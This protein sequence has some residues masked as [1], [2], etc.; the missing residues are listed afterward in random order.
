MPEKFR[1]HFERKTLRQGYLLHLENRVVDVVFFRL[2]YRAEVMDGDRRYV[3]HYRHRGFSAPSLIGNS[4]CSCRNSAPTDFCAHQAALLF[5]VLSTPSGAPTTGGKTIGESYSASFWASLALGLC[6]SFGGLP[7]RFAPEP[8][9]VSLVTSENA[10]VLGFAIENDMD[11]LF[12]AFPEKWES[13]ASGHLFVAWAREEIQPQEMHELKML[14]HTPAKRAEFGAAGLACRV[15]FLLCLQPRGLLNWQEDRELFHIQ[16]VDLASDFQALACLGVEPAFSL[17][18]KFPQIEL[19]EGFG[20]EQEIWRKGLEIRVDQGGRLRIRPFATGLAVSNEEVTRMF[21]PATGEGLW[22]GDRNHLPGIG[23]RRLQP[24]SGALFQRYS[25]WK[26][27]WVEA[28]A[29]SG[30]L[31]KY[32]SELTSGPDYDL[33]P[34]LERSRP[35][36][37]SRMRVHRIGREENRFRVNLEYALG[38]TA[39]DLRALHSLLDS[40]QTC[41]ITAG[42]WVDLSAPEWSWLSRLKSGDWVREGEGMH[43]LLDRA[44]L[45]RICVMH[46]PVAIEVIS[47]GEDSLDFLT[48]L[49]Q[50]NSGGPAI[51]FGEAQLPTAGLRSYQADGLRWLAQLADLGL[52]GI[53][54]DDMGLGKTHQVMA[55]CAWLHERSQGREKF[56]IVCPTSVLYH[57]KEKFAKFHPGLE[58]GVYHGP[59]R[60]AA[61]L[62]LPLCITSYGIARNDMALFRQR[63]YALLVLDEI[64]YSKNRD[65]ETHKSLRD[66]PARSTIG[67]TG[68][69]LENSVWEVKNLFDLILPG[70]FPGEAQFR[71]EIAEPLEAI[72]ARSGGIGVPAALRAQADC[73]RE[74]FLRLTR[75][76]MLRRLKSQVLDDLPEKIEETYHCEMTADQADLYHATLKKRGGPLLSELLGARPASLMHVFQ[77]LN[78]LKQICNHPMTLSGADA[79]DREFGSGKWELF[80]FLLEKSLRSGHKVVVFSQYLNMLAWM[81]RH[82]E[83]SGIGYVTLTG[84]TTHRQTVLNRFATDPECRVFCCSLKAGGVG[85]DLTAAETVIHYDRWWNAARENQ[86][87]DRVHRIGQL[88]NVQVFK[89]VT[90]GTIEDR[91][92][93]IIQRKAD[94]MD[95]LIPDAEGG[96]QLFTREELVELLRA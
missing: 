41:L 6:R 40:G 5:R 54:A 16:V 68:T 58:T 31:A 32:S 3:C 13:S 93:A 55:L 76:F 17:H 90:R 69:P 74:R 86:A 72:P 27:Y 33:D 44:Q 14:G 75:P 43:A 39:L 28:H 92:D 65:S 47:T 84:A 8:G 94:F 77:L 23:F 82:L 20:N 21:P 1:K 2:V 53:L 62:D 88:K 46:A 60:D 79:P 15:A 78:H 38:D 95:S 91:I 85:I 19:G 61:L 34:I 42:G 9:R 48:S 50:G 57:W 12:N 49:P 96:L 26:T 52:S 18:K 22:F 63:R 35:A 7:L 10:P 37:I 89:L 87:T 59:Q 67:L 24:G 81:E 71:G 70:Y 11:N 64:H 83:K 29:V 30:F 51:A 4:E 66:F 36:T 25:G 56:L 45:T 80:Q 73:A